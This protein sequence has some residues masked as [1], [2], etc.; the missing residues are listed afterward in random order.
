MQFIEH[1]LTVSSLLPIVK[2]ARVRRA[3]WYF[4]DTA[5]RRELWKSS[6]LVYFVVQYQ[7]LPMAFSWSPL[8]LNECD[9]M[10]KFNKND[11]LGKQWNMLLNAQILDARSMLNQR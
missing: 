2:Y 3:D 10:M 7:L 9:L 4:R 1:S 5:S 6:S 8:V 11:E